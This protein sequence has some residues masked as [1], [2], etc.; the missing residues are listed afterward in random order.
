MNSEDTGMLLAWVVGAWMITTII[1]GVS[2][3]IAL[4]KIIQEMN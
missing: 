1:L 4:T 3:A 2:F